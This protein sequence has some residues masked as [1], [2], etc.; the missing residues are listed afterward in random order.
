MTTTKRSVGEGRPRTTKETQAASLRP[1]A[2]KKVK[3]EAEA[4][5]ELM[6]QAAFAGPIA[7]IWN[8]P[9]EDEAWAHLKDIP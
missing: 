8:T 3:T 4:L 5:A 7:E 2:G 9:K 6:T 1:A